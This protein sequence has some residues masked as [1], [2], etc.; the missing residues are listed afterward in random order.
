M[1]TKWEVNT[2]IKGKESQGGVDPQRKGGKNPTKGENGEDM[3]LLRR[4]LRT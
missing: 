2:S 3:M 4:S 1:D